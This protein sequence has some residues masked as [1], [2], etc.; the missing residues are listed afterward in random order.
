MANTTTTQKG[1]QL[2]CPC[3]G[4]ASANID[5]HLADASFS[6]TECGTDFTRE[7]IDNLIRRWT[8]LLKWVDAMPGEE[9]GP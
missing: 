1:I 8:K 2:P 5:L 7:D 3:C 9:T 4:E 6:C